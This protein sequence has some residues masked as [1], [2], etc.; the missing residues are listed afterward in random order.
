MFKMFDARAARDY[1]SIKPVVP[2]DRKIIK[3]RE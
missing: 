2:D 1:W 3:C